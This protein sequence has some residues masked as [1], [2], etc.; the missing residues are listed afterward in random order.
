MSRIAD[1]TRKAPKPTARGNGSPSTVTATA[2]AVSGSTLVII[3]VGTE[4]TSSMARNMLVI[5]TMKST[6]TRPTS[7][8]P[9]SDSGMAMPPSGTR[10]SAE[11]AAAPTAM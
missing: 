2:I 7:A 1:I 3:A 10:A 9:S 5:A 4:P 8:R 11:S 6:V